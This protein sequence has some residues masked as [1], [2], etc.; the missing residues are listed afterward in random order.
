[1]A[2]RYPYRL[3]RERGGAGYQMNTCGMPETEA[4]E[5][6]AYWTVAELGPASLS[7]SLAAGIC[8]SS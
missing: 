7:F 3:P 4:E 8:C 2:L 1:M 6:A 5:V